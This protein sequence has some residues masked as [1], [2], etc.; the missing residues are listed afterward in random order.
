MAEGKIINDPVFGFIKIPGGPLMDIVDH[1]LMQRL[2]HIKQLGLASVVYPGAQHTRFQHS[3]GAFHLMSEAVVS[4]GQKGIFIFDSEAEAIKAAILMHDIGHGPYSHVLEHTLMEGV[5]HEDVSLMMMEQINSEMNGCL[6]LAL[7]IFKDQYPKHFLHQLISSQLDMDRLD[8]L[9]RDSFFTGV[10]EGNIGSA[11]IIKMLN[12][13][14]DR[15]VVDSKGIY[16]IENYLTSRRL[17]Y[18][19]VY[20][21]KTTVGTEKMLVNLLS[22][23]KGLMQEG[24][25]LFATPSLRYFLQN[26]V[27]LDFFQ[28]HKEALDYYG[29]L[30]D[31]DIHCSIKEWTKSDDK[32]L[33]LLAQN[34]VNRR[35][36][37]VEIHET[38]ISQDRLAELE[39]ELIKKTGVGREEVKHL[40]NVSTIQKDMYDIHDDRITILYKDG[41]MKDI[42]EAS[43]IL[44]VQLLSKKIRK[45]YLC[46]HKI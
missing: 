40:Y 37:K 26:H 17:M 8:Y 4:L 1:P 16:S 11:R 25:D 6:N 9:R 46:Y 44:N 35:P 14:D 39:D 5:S 24:K 2:R 13:V 12:V 28:N 3:L 20:L 36:F 32:V 23:A 7:N 29:H 31:T 38:P 15:L 30:D 22:R 27:D 45:Y 19:Q 21:H 34:T 42:T 33:S 41:V 10:T 43:E 18:W